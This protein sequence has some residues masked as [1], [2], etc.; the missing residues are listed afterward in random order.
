MSLLDDHM[1][2]MMSSGRLPIGARTE[3]DECP[4]MTVPR[5]RARSAKHFVRAG[6]RTAAED[7]RRRGQ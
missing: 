6:R 5:C 2:G 3:G 1:P 4:R 7:C